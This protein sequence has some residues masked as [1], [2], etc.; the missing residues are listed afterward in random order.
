MSTL[1]AV[2]IVYFS[3]IQCL[4]VLLSVGKS[5][6]SHSNILKE[7]KVGHLVPHQWGIKANNK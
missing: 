7:P 2:I 1:I 5:C 6:S 3:P 4:L